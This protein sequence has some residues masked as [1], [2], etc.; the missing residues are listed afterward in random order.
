MTERFSATACPPAEEPPAKFA[1]TLGGHFVTS[2]ACVMKTRSP[3]MMGVE[4]PADGSVTFQRTF[5]VALHLSGR[6]FSSDT[7]WPV[8]PRQPGQ[9]S[10]RAE[11]V[12]MATT[13]NAT[14]VLILNRSNDSSRMWIVKEPLS[15][16]NAGALTS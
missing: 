12:Q 2:L 11:A 14:V 9:L 15:D 6:S 13:S 16:C 4:L 10:A 3:Q 5:S 1:G 7:P 8:G